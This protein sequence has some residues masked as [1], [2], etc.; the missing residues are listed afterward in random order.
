[1]N[2]TI[3]RVEV[4]RITKITIDEIDAL[5]GIYVVHCPKTGYTKFGRAM[6]MRDRLQNYESMCLNGG[7]VVILAKTM[8]PKMITVAED[9]L[10]SIATTRLKHID[11]HEYFLCESE[12]VAR[13]ILEDSILYLTKYYVQIRDILRPLLDEMWT[14][15]N[16]SQSTEEFQ[17]KASEV[18]EKIWGCAAKIK[19]AEHME[20]YYL[21]HQSAIVE[22]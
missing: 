21:T 22:E 6:K 20:V 4:E 19:H 1:M 13:K 3:K 10:L 7:G 15:G 11:K 9:V 14:V 16:E 8:S 12:E 18:Y 2:D 5:P 17:R